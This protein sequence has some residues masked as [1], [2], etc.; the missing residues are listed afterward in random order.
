[1]SIFYAQAQGANK[2]LPGP[3]CPYEY[4]GMCIRDDNPIKILKRLYFGTKYEPIFSNT[5]AESVHI[6]DPKMLMENPPWPE[7]DIKTESATAQKILTTLIIIVQYTVE[8]MESTSDHK[9]YQTL[10]K[11]FDAHVS[12]MCAFEDE[13]DIK[14]ILSDRRAVE[15][16]EAYEP[17]PIESMHEGALPD[18]ILELMK[19]TYWNE[20]KTKMA[21][22]VHLLCK[23]LPQRCQIRNLQDIILNYCRQDDLVYDFM[24]KTVLC[25]I[26]GAYS[27]SKR[28][29]SWKT[30]IVVLRRL[31][32]SP[33]NRTQMQEWLFGGYQHFLF[34]VIKEFLTYSIQLIPSLF[35]E[36]RDTYKWDAFEFCVHNAMDNMRGQLEANVNKST[37]IKGWLE[38]IEP[39]LM[40]INKQ[41][42]GNLFRPQRMSFTQTILNLCER[43]DEANNQAKPYVKFPREYRNLMRD[44]SK[45]HVRSPMVPVEWLKYFGV[46]SNAIESLKN[47]Q[48]HYHQNTFRAD[49][50]KLLNEVSR[51]DFEA[52][53]ELFK[54]F[55]Q[56]HHMVRVFPLP[57]HYYIS[58]IRALR[59]R[60]EIQ[61]GE[62]LSDNVGQVYACLACHTFKAFVVKSN[63]KVS[64][65]FANGHHKVI[66]NDETLKCYCGRRS[67]QND[68][69]KRP[70]VAIQEFVHNNGENEENLKRQRK[71]Q[72]K[73]RRKKYMNDECSQTECLKF[74]MC[75]V[76]FQF[77]NTIYMFCPLCAS[78]TVFDPKQHGKYGLHC[79]QCM[80]D[81]EFYTRVA[82]IV[83]NSLRGAA[84]WD[85]VP[86][87]DDEDDNKEKS[88]VICQTCDRSWIHS[89]GSPYKLS[90]LKTRC[91]RV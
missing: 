81:G 65:L 68:S 87:I 83:C 54:V 56:V 9:I 6:L 69:K 30:R 58:Q 52:I 7:I 91:N 59:R 29:L 16:S 48:K 37:T 33:P 47:I 42:L 44:M 74:N 8:C 60:Y 45:R 73:M 36:I 32:Y 71:K 78:P 51:Y 49:V 39:M 75:G 57:K 19:C 88:G 15:L 43:L 55:Y 25:S 80:K 10:T 67:D 1:M 3:I 64:N 14:G 85:T 79:G 62:K 35:E 63:D 28:S 66:I 27:H 90:V 41:Q 86:Y 31:V 13:M 20:T 23:S 38:G 34:Y 2:P 18:V 26:L 82:C 76:L 72:W 53:R 12:L 4:N 70:R 46:D 40:Q 77:Y 84:K 11:F 5:F 89:D 17:I 24:S 61:N 50:K 21:P 22:V